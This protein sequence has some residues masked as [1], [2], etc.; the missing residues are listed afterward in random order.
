MDKIEMKTRGGIMKS[1]R[2]NTAIIAALS[3]GCAIAAVAA[4]FNALPSGNRQDNGADDRT[5]VT[6]EGTL[7]INDVT[8]GCWYL[9]TDS[10]T[11]YEPIFCVSEPIE[12][13]EGLRVKVL[14]YIDSDAPQT[15][16]LGPVFNALQ[17]QVIAE[18]HMA[19]IE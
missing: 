2:Q 10:G 15:C 3:L 4:G 14:G 17:T 8:T 6:V 19:G 5:M 18:T 16:G 9:R 11:L 13:K 7:G 1:L 12:L